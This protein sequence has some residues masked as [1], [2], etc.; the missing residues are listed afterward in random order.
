MD[1]TG[2]QGLPGSFNASICSLSPHTNHCQ[3]AKSTHHRESKGTTSEWRRS[4]HLADHTGFFFQVT[5][6]VQYQNEKRPTGQQEVLSYEILHGKECLAT[7][8]ACFI[9]VLNRAGPAQK[10]PVKRPHLSCECQQHELPPKLSF[11][12]SS[13]ITPA[14]SHSLSPPSSRGDFSPPNDHLPDL[15]YFFLMI[16]FGLREFLLV[17]A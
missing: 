6:S 15:C 8:M 9:S 13:S 16:A 10:Q 1:N 7:S 4:R 12:H 17:V 14:K 2:N 11:S 5:S 3:S